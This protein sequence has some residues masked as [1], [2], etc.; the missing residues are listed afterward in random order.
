MYGS[1]FCILPYNGERYVTVRTLVSSSIVSHTNMYQIDIFAVVPFSR[2]KSLIRF[3]RVYKYT[4]N[5]RSVNIF[6]KN[7]NKKSTM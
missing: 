5:E 4:K 7:L 3:G 1:L 2:A 6:L